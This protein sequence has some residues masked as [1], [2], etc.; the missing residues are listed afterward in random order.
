MKPTRPR[1][2]GFVAAALVAILFFLALVVGV[3]LRVAWLRH[4]DLRAAERRLQAE[5]LAESALG[6]ASARLGADPSYKGETWEVAADALGGR[7][8]GSVRIE[9]AAVP[10]HPDRRAV[11]VRADYPAAEPR[12][13][14]RSHELTVT[15]APRSPTEPERQGDA[16]K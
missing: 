8:A 3:L 4:A 16:P 5:W 1:R 6:R 11:R 2:R 12:R 14:R 15:L 10:D 13:A 7:D 9:V